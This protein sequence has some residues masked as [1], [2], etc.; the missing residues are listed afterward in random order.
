MITIGCLGES[1]KRRKEEDGANG[2]IVNFF[3]RCGGVD[4][5]NGQ[6]GLSEIRLRISDIDLCHFA[7]WRSP[8]ELLSTRRTNTHTLYKHKQLD[9]CTNGQRDFYNLSVSGLSLTVP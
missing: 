8:I 3:V 9:S 6:I 1:G 4:E 7:T 5:R 2:A